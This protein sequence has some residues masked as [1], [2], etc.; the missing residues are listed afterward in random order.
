[1]YFR[2]AL[3]IGER[4]L[5]PDHPIIG[6]AT[7]NLGIL[8]ARQQ[9]YLGAETL[10]TRALGINLRRFGVF[11]PHTAST[12]E[13]LSS[14]YAVQGK[15]AEAERLIRTSLSILEAS[16]VAHGDPQMRASLEV[17]AAILRNTN[18]D[19]QAQEIEQRLEAGKTVF[20]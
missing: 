16:Q 11:H 5:A 1:V 19:R 8:Y 13:S 17:F 6:V 3:E 12:L 9:K 18:R 7:Q 20:Q 14:F 2:R 4:R 15:M 10:L